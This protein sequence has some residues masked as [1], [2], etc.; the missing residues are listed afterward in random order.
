M[1][2]SHYPTGFSTEITEQWITTITIESPSAMA[3]F[4]Q[5]LKLALADDDSNL[6]LYDSEIE[7]KL[8]KA[9]EIIL[10]P[11]TLDFN[12]KRIKSKLYSLI[13]DIVL[14][15]FSDSFITVKSN[16]YKLVEDLSEHLPYTISYNTDLD[17]VSFVKFLD[18][19]I[20][21]CDNTIT[22]RIVEYMKLN[23]SLCYVQVF[24]FINLKSYISSE[25]MKLIY[26]EAAYL[27]IVLVLIE[28]VQ[29]EKLEGERGFIIDSDKCIIAI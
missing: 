4:I 29:R 22:Q 25:D 21:Q 9:A 6:I 20:E 13:S 23:V 26:K 2:I 24:F 7:I 10:D 19:K 28:N 17:A 18:I 12:S 8:S 11:W 3:S 27:H 14:D 5:D 1:I 16:L 15:Q